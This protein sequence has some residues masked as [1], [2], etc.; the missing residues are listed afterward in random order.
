MHGEYRDS[1]ERPRPEDVRRLTF[2]DAALGRRAIEWERVVPL[3]KVRAGDTQ[4]RVESRRG[5]GIVTPFRATS[6]DHLTD[7]PDV[8][9]VVGVGRVQAARPLPQIRELWINEVDEATLSNLPN[10]RM[11]VFGAAPEKRKLDA[12]ALPPSLRDL[13]VN[14]YSGIESVEPL[15]R[16][17]GLERLALDSA[18]DVSLKPLAELENLRWLITHPGKDLRALAGLENLELVHLYME[19]ARLSHLKAFRRWAKLTDLEIRERGLRSL[20]GIEAFESLERLHLHRTGVSELAPLAGHPALQELELGLGLPDRVRD[21]PP[22]RLPALRRLRIDLHD[23]APPTLAFLRGCTAL[24]EV[25]LIGGGAHDRDPSPIAELPALK[26]LAF[27]GDYPAEAVEAVIA[28]R[29]EATISW[30]PPHD[31]DAPRDPLEPFALP[32]GTWTIFGDVSNLLDA[33]SNHDAERRIRSTV[34]KAEPELAKRLDYDSEGSAFAVTGSEA[35]LRRVAEIIRGL[36]SE[37]Q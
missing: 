2:E 30:Q 3:A 36:A 6:L 29:P 4:V 31:W 1:R 22:L 26:R 11:L 12:N 10:L 20:E 14:A 7:F 23:G 27:Y 13:S 17:H 8:D 15:A 5:E 35:D 19:S 25:D 9:S 18:F 37:R 16:L 33:A 28:A 21:W 32:D 24:E 34:R